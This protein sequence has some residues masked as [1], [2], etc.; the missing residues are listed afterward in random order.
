MAEDVTKHRTINGKE[1]YVTKLYGEGEEGQF[2]VVV[3]KDDEHSVHTGDRASS[4]NFITAKV[5]Q[6]K[7]EGS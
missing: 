3:H 5:S 7:V 4:E 6:K 2:H 1:V